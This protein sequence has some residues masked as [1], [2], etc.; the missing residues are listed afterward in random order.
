MSVYKPLSELR[1]S[2]AVRGESV[3]KDDNNRGDA[4]ENYSHCCGNNG[5]AKEDPKS[6]SDTSTQTCRKQNEAAHAIH[7]L[8]HFRHSEMFQEPSTIRQ[9]ISID[10]LT[11]NHCTERFT[12][13]RGLFRQY[14]LLCCKWEVTAHFDDC[15]GEKGTSQTED[16][17]A[18]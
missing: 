11:A 15:Q 13:M 5:L 17:G 12:R 9:E 14:P 8:V 18:V 16:Y 7:H 3:C 10:F 2:L 1:P 4:K 6:E